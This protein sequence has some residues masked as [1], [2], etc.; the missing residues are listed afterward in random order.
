MTNLQLTPVDTWFFRD[1][2]PITTDT[3]P[4]NNP[5]NLFP[6]YPTTV[7][8]AVRAALALGAG[9]DGK[10][11]WSEEIS[12]I[13][14][15]GPDNMGRLRL[16]GPFLLRD[17]QPLFQMPR[18]LLGPIVRGKWCPKVMLRPGRKVSCDLG[19]VPLPEVPRET[20]EVETLK[21]G[22]GY[23]LAAKGMKSVLEGQIPDQAEVICHQD[24]W[25]E[26]PRIGLERD[27][28]RTAKDGMLYS[29][30]HI[31]P[32]KEV[33]LGTRITGIPEDWTARIKMV[34]LGGESR[35][36]ECLDWNGDSILGLSLKPITSNRI[37][38]MALTPLDLEKDYYLG[39]K[40]LIEGV[41]VVSACLDR[42]L[43]IGGWDS[44]KRRPLPMRSILPSGSVLFCETKE[45]PQQFIES[46]QSDDGLLHLGER[47]S[48]GFG[49]VAL[50]AWPSDKEESP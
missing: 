44:L 4:Q 24:L 26:E 19:D 30:C 16:A 15:D 49:V 1:G 25:A 22:D 6:P 2:T 21:T 34:P 36:S 41:R 35:F 32:K 12:K 14:G 7:V 5:G 31:R 40:D 37:I 50:G 48:H 27:D 17:G 42:P 23:W 9:W 38:I 10:K 29:T 39:Q 11:S 20:K 47:T 45:G 28:H 18:H 33:S 3:A 46:L 43:R 13:L 8:G